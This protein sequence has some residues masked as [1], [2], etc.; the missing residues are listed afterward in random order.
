MSGLI[1]KL[2]KML[3][4]VVY[5]QPRDLP[6]VPFAVRG[7]EVVDDGQVPHEVRPFA[8]LAAARHFIFGRLPGARRINRAAEDD[9]VVVETWL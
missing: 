4:F 9:P 2:P 7:W 3:L 5:R 8:S 1:T 6:G